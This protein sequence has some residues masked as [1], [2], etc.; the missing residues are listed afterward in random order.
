MLIHF[1]E[2]FALPVQEVYSYFSSPAEWPRLYGMAGRPRDLGAGWHAISLHRFPFPLVARNTE[3]IAN[4]RVRWTFRGFWR[5]EGEVR[6][7]PTPEGVLLQGYERISVRWLFRLSPIVER[8]F[9]ERQFRA[10]WQLGWERLHKR[11][12]AGAAAAA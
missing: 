8:L 4:E 10:I 6:F 3:T 5:G 9:L 11:A 7:T 1:N 2:R 12:Q